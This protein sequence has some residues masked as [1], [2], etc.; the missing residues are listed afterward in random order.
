MVEHVEGVRP[1][2][3]V[4]LPRGNKG[5][6]LRE[7]RIHVEEL[8]SAQVV[9]A[10]DLESGWPGEGGGGGSRVVEHE[11]L[12]ADLVD[13]TLQ[14]GGVADQ[15]SGCIVRVTGYE[16]ARRGSEGVAAVVRQQAADIPAANQLIQQTR[17]GGEEGASASNRQLIGEVS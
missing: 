3:Q 9:A 13:T 1:E 17:V 2:L 11:E 15:D 10:A 7:A 16:R 14:Q 5:E 6:G 4:D 12:V 8:G